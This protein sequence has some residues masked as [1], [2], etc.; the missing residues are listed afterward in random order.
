MHAVVVSDPN[1]VILPV[2]FGF[3]IMTK[4]SIWNLGFTFVAEL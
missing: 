3:H 1:G 2:Q 4:T